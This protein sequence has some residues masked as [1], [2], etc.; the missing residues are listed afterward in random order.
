MRLADALG[1]AAIERERR[2]RHDERRHLEPRNDEA[3]DEAGERADAK[4]ERDRQRQRK[5]EGLPGIAEHDR[6]QADDRADREVDA[7]GDDDE[8]HRQRDEPDLGHQPAL[9]E[10]V[11]E[12]EEAVVEGAEADQRDNENDREQCLVPLKP[13]RGAK[14]ADFGGNAHRFHPLAARR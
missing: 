5:A 7:A 11:V 6:A 13:A 4:R 3:V 2:D 1:E 10:E 12:G 14:A 8:G 9:V